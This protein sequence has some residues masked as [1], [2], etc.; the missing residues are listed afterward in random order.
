MQF[1]G[2]DDKSIILQQLRAKIVKTKSLPINSITRRVIQEVKLKRR[3][4][5]SSISEQQEQQI[6]ERFWFAMASQDPDN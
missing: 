2:D 6:A 5:M 3:E 4:K 1:S